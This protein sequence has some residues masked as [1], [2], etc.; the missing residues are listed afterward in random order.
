[1][2]RCVVCGKHE[3]VK[4]SARHCSDSIR[5]LAKQYDMLRHESESHIH[6]LC[7]RSLRNSEKNGDKPQV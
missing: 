5:T 2:G 1:M 4:G 6:E 3:G 7:L